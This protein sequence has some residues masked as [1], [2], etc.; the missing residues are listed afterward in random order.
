MAR[1]PVPGSE[2]RLASEAGDESRRIGGLS[3]AE[4]R[5]V[6][7][8]NDAAAQR[9]S[10][11]RSVKAAAAPGILRQETTTVKEKLHKFESSPP[12]PPKNVASDEFV[13]RVVAERRR[14]LD[15]PRTRD[16]DVAKPTDRD[17]RPKPPLP[18]RAIRTGAPREEPTAP[19]VEHPSSGTAGDVP[20]PNPSHLSFLIGEIRQQRLR[21]E[22][23]R[24]AG[25][26]LAE[27]EK[28]REETAGEGWGGHRTVGPPPVPPPR[29]PP[30][31]SASSTASD[32]LD[33]TPAPKPSVLLRPERRRRRLPSP[34]E[35]GPPPPK[36]PRPPKV[37]LPSAFGRLGATPPLPQRNPTRSVSA[38]IPGSP[39][40]RPTKAVPPPPATP[41]PAE[42][43]RPFTA[44]SVSSSSFAKECDRGSCGPTSPIPEYTEEEELGELYDDAGSHRISATLSSGG[45]AI[46]VLPADDPHRDGGRPSSNDSDELYEDVGVGRQT[47]SESGVPEAKTDDRKKKDDE[48]KTKKL[49]KESEKKRRETEKLRKRFKLTGDEAAVKTGVIKATTRGRRR[50]DLSVRQG[51]AISILRISD[52]PVG[53][54]LVQNE[55]GRVGYVDLANIEVMS[56][57]KVS[58]VSRDDSSETYADDDD[59]DLSEEGIYEEFS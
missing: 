38:P 39:A 29:L 51:D 40:M 53:K 35:L 43:V 32:D 48:K 25:D 18:A 9:S 46:S 5:S 14:D 13:P 58:V 7:Q 20:K 12:L 30:T 33:P 10:P 37:R 52:N 21:R 16:D 11:I 56:G 1:G 44:F 4:L 59:D 31:S 15:G 27:D 50:D 57:S 19:F 2:E 17:E 24:S 49:L 28:E 41:L 22:S 6:F 23:S 8:K 3:I 55:E 36:P 54:W 47:S 34:A 26:G 42:P 45:S